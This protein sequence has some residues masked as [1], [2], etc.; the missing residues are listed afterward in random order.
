MTS[1]F[2]ESMPQARTTDLLIEVLRDETLVYDLRRHRAHCLNRAAALVWKH[3]DGR[4]TVAATATILDEALRLSAGE[5]LVRTGLD[6][7]TRALD[8][9]A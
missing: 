1:G 2:G 4:T 3:C 8:G 7:L 6:Q 5:A 9:R